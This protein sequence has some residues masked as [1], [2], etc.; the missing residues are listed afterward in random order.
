V[1]DKCLTAEAAYAGALMWLEPAKVLHL[2]GLMQPDDFESPQ[3]RDVHR[4]IG[5]LA[6]QGVQPHALA[7]YLQADEDGLLP[8][9]NHRHVFT[10]L[11]TDL[12]GDRDI[13][14]SNAR[15]F[16]T[17]ALGQAVRRRTAEMSTRLAQIAD[18]ADDDELERMTL[19]EQAAVQ[20]LRERFHSLSGVRTLR[21]QEAA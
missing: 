6:R 8:T 1:T 18:T 2:Y 16:A 9:I 11:V 15:Y 10:R 17:K 14:P 7:L 20:Q 5:E 13:V 12:Y 19:R 21:R 4:L 3:M